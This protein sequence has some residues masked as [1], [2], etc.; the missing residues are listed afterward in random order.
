MNSWEVLRLATDRIGAKALAAKLNLST[1]LIYKW[2]QE[3]PTDEDPEAS[4]AR[5][6]LDRIGAVYDATQDPE[7]I[8]W[9][10]MRAGGFYVAN[11]DI[12]PGTE[13]TELLTTTQ[14]LVQDFGGLLSE[15]STG[16][17]DD[18]LINA[19]EAERIRQSW[20]RL[21][22]QAEKFVVAC[23]QGYF[24]LEGPEKGE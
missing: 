11:P 15:I 4:G 17:E 20:E 24:T 8:N 1:A 18:G 6:P 16:F 23:E 22:T 2:C 10:C 14:R 7:I 5:N 21:K 19:E 12:Q 3:P 9:L 13:D